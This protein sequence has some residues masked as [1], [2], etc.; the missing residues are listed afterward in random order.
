MPKFKLR[1]FSKKNYNWIKP[2]K[3][4]ETD[5]PTLYLL[6]WFKTVEVDNKATEPTAGNEND[7]NNLSLKKLKTMCEE[8]WIAFNSR[9]SKAEI[10][11]LLQDAEPTAGNEND[12]EWEWTE[13]DDDLVQD[14][15]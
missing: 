3:M 11:K 14:L 15:D 6:N 10:I 1:N 7:L 9:A 8:K 5:N 2:W 12:E 13:T 4:V